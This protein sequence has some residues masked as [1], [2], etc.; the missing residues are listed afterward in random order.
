[1][2]YNLIT[3]CKLGFE[4][5]LKDELHALGYQNLIVENG[6]ISF[7]GNEEAIARCN[8]WL[9][10]AERVLV[11]LAYFPATTFDQLFEGVSAL[12]WAGLM[13]Q[14]GKI[15]V[16]DKCLNSQLMSGRTVQ[17]I[18]KKAIVE[19][20]KKKQGVDWIEESGPEF[21]IHAQIL[22]DQVSILL[23]SSGIGLHKRG[24]R[25]W[26]GEAPLR[27][28]AAAAMVLLS[29]WKPE[30]PLY[31][32]LCGSGTICIEAAMIGAN[33]APGLRRRFAAEDWPFISADV[34][35][36]M[37]KEAESKISQSGMVIIGSDSDE[38]M[39]RLADGNAHKAGVEKLVRFERKSAEDFVTKEE[40]GVVITNPPYGE[41][42][43]DIA[44]AEKIYKI[45]GN[46]FPLKKAWSYFILSPHSAFEKLFGRKAKKNRKIYNGKIKCYLYHFI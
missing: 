24:Y 28:T 3:T 44:S 19:Q 6:E 1:M 13:P 39:I 41:R 12:D 35:K 8:L 34:W 18:V 30:K 27:E 23:D 45:L 46:V 32:P 38:K 4:S 5:V 22:H 7:K 21:K 11:Q 2:T 37:R 29:N 43:E 9:R 16:E 25:A 14:D 31:D 20:M 15:D 40:R 26:A 17:S 33:I 10:T 36:K 42:L